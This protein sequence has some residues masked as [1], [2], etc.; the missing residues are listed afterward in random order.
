VSYAKS[1][2]H[3]LL[4]GTSP[5]P[6][7]SCRLPRGVAILDVADACR[8]AAIDFMTD[9]PTSQRALAAWQDGMYQSLVTIVEP[10]LR[11]AP[12]RT[13]AVLELPAFTRA[14]VLGVMRGLAYPPID[15]SFTVAAMH[16]GWIERCCDGFGQ[17]GWVPLDRPN[18]R[19]SERVLSL[20]AV[21]YLV[22]PEEWQD[23]QLLHAASKIAV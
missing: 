3:E 18:M 15:V 12:L 13:D 21:D 6:P 7:P 16:D 5:P 2:V 19:L 9:T 8:R 17:T 23:G 11:R 1:D 14:Y 22:R 4:F 10:D 20:I